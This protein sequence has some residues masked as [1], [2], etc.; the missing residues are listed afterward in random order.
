[1]TKTKKILL[2]ISVGIILS[3]V[4]VVGAALW[5]TNIDHYPGLKDRIS[6]YYQA[7]KDHDWAKTYRMRPPIFQKHITEQQYF[8]EMNK[9]SEGWKLTDFK[10]VLVLPKGGRVEVAMTVTEQYKGRGSTTISSE[11]YSVWQNI[12]GTWYGVD[13]GSRMHFPFNSELVR[14][15]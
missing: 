7:E 13:T 11:I 8:E 2:T 12:G 10:T 5:L 9:G 4:V 15:K 6:E 1:M 3:V 14:E